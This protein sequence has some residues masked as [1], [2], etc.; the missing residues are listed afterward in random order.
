MY[1]NYLKIKHTFKAK[2]LFKLEHII[3]PKSTQKIKKNFI[4]LVQKQQ[5][6]HLIDNHENNY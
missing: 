3:I 5:P 4:F 6:V 1:L 2:S